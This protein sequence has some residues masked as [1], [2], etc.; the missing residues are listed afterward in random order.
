MDIDLRIPDEDD[1]P[2]R[3]QFLLD[4]IRKNLK[5]L[6]IRNSTE[7]CNFIERQL[8]LLLDPVE[9]SKTTEQYQKELETFACTFMK[10]FEKKDRCIGPCRK[11]NINLFL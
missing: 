7:E 10:Q 9:L 8:A 4:Q 11:Q 6:K 1:L 5:I 3:I 2:E